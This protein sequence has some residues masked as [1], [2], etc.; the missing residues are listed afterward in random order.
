MTKP[1]FAEIIAYLELMTGRPI[2]DDPAR[3]LERTRGYYQALGDLP[4]DVLRAAAEKLVIE[5]KWPT[6]PQVAELRELATNIL[7]RQNAI[8]DVGEAWDMARRAALTMADESLDYKVVN[9]EQVPTK[10][11]N[12]RRLSKLPWCVAEALRQFTAERIC[13]TTNDQIGT[14]FAQFRTVYET[15]AAKVKE[16]RLLPDGLRRRVDALPEW[17]Q[18]HAGSI[19]RLPA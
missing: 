15:C 9:G 8:P 4:V 19:G 18:S 2:H 13:N 3:A 7:H 14:A 6:F 5:R 12:Q 1:E 11:W 10:E 17:V 16:G